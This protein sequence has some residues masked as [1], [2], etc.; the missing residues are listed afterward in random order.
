MDTTS[1]SFSAPRLARRGAAAIAIGAL[2][3]IGMVM[4][5]SG[6]SDP[7]P[8][9]HG[10]SASVPPSVAPP[11]SAAPTGGGLA[12]APGRHA[13]PAAP[14]AAP[15]TPLP[16]LEDGRHP[17]YLTDIDVP[18]ST[19]EFDLLQALATDAEREAYASSHAHDGDPS[20]GSPFRNENPRLR[21]LPVMPDIAV[22][23]Q[24]S[25]REGCDGRQLMDYATF[26]GNIRARSYDIGH[27][28]TNPF[29]LTVHGGTVL[30]LEEMPC[31]G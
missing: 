14:V 12:A 15:S 19:V 11:T 31:A 7:T 5:P 29:W 13:D 3:A 10:G 17:V 8:D 6:E 20:H 1:R 2:A 26:A 4:W 18:G 23:V 30:A 27:M 16:V 9:D 28:G 21:R 24:Q 22:A 25:G